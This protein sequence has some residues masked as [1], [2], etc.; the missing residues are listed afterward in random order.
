[1]PGLSPSRASDY[2]QCPLLFRLRVVDR[3]PEPPSPAAVRG[4]MV[5]A[6]LEQLFDL[7]A[8][9]R[10]LEAAAA[11]LAPVWE[12]M[13][14][15]EP[16]V[17]EVLDGAGTDAW[18]ENATA[19]LRTYFTLEDP[20]RLAPAE[21]ELA[22]RL[23]TEEGW[24]LRGIVDRLDVAPNGAM[25]VVDY[26][27]GRSPREGFEASALFQM[28]FYALVLSRLRGQVPAMLQLVYL[29]DGVVLRHVPD[30]AE[31]AGTERKVRAIWSG[32][33]EAATRGEFQPR[34]GPLCDWCAHQSLCP[35]FGGTPPPLDA[36]AVEHAVGVR[37]QA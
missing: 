21:R 16:R 5:H 13:V 30:D 17:A 35:L 3:V 22:V 1:M 10:T 27:T 11:L 26:K 25:R 34:R 23:D 29:G 7:P 14:E 32:I 8:G 31:L 4:T 18:F 19:L 9:A 36:D 2:L 6:V 28:K 33:R 20:N 12:A 37:P 24:E 15:A